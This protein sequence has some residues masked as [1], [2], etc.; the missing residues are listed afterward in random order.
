MAIFFSRIELQGEKIS[1][2][3]MKC[4]RRRRRRLYAGEVG[5]RATYCVD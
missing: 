3:K 1:S 4:D 5:H 2:E